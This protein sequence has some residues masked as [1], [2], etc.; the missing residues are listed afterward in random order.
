MGC[1]GAE[2]DP[3]HEGHWCG[4]RTMPRLMWMLGELEFST[5]K[6]T[7][8]IVNEIEEKYRQCLIQHGV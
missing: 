3:E 4:Y 6:N 8:Y 2:G 7:I 5:E 1:K